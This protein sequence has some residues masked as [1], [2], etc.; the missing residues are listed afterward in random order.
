[1]SLS[2]GS[3]L[4]KLEATDDSEKEKDKK[5]SHMKNGYNPDNKNYGRES[6]T[7]A[8]ICDEAT[9][10]D[11][12]IALVE[13]GIK[14]PKAWWGARHTLAF[15]GFLGFAC[16][17]AM[18]VN[19][20]VAIVAMVKSEVKNNTNNTDDSEECPLP[21]DYNPEDNANE[22]GDFEWNE[23]TQGLILGCFFYGYVFTNLLGGRAAEYW[24]GKLVF[25][26]GLVIT[27]ALT[28]VSPLCAE[29]STGL[30]IAVRVLEG[31]AEG[32]TFP[33]M[34]SLLAVWVP[35]IERS[36]F[37]TLVYA[38]V[39]FGTVVTMPVSGW[40]CDTD[41]LGGWPSVFYV[42]GALGLFWGIAWFLLIY[43]HPEVHPRISPEEKNYVIQHCGTKKGKPL[44]IPLKAIF[45]SLPFWAILVAH[46]GN[47]WGFY[48]LLTELPSYLKNIQ[49]FDMKSNGVLSALPYFVM[50]IFSLI[51]SFIMDRLQSN[52]KLSAIAVRRISMCLALYG[53]MLGLIAMCFVNCNQ[54]LA[55]V[56]LCI[57][58]GL[59][60]AVYCGY[61]CSHQDL[62]PKFAGT[63]MGITNT[64][65]TIPG[66]TAP[67]VVGFITND[68]QTL[69]AWRTIFLISA[70]VYFVSN[71]FYLIFIRA[72][73][74]P[75]SYQSEV[76]GDKD[77]TK[78]RY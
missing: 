69:S 7:L 2:L 34:N 18:R 8:T 21:D 3:I 70:V 41:F 52:G 27:A 23:A 19:L 40:L 42:F 49:H 38:G 37:S 13:Y 28:I 60:G 33:A 58:V 22:N 76:E 25:G 65:A 55:M 20:S 59:N 12:N 14:K 77:E 35:R 9:V 1:M 57:S 74:Q 61:M 11:S 67:S 71:T 4:S 54:V 31:A 62:A 75:W 46:V 48:T 6:Q 10:G 56:V 30:F 26:V 63:L 43:N 47:N 51:Y 36:K 72:D 66:F 50:W 5:Q 45:T 29:V 15:L 16:V 78:K 53:P 32:V 24:G 17:Y 39:Q 73:E 44:P 68:N 64:A